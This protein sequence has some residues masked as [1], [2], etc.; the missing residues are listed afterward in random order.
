[1]KCNP[2]SAN[3]LWRRI[4]ASTLVLALCLPGGSPPHA[5]EVVQADPQPRLRVGPVD[6]YWLQKRWAPADGLTAERAAEFEVEARLARA[7]Q[8][9]IIRW[10]N[11]L[12]LRLENGLFVW[13]VDMGD[14]SVAGF[15]CCEVYRLADVWPDLGFYVVF[16]SRDESAGYLL[17]SAR[18]AAAVETVWA[19]HRDPATPGLLVS[20]L[21][22]DM[23]GNAA[24]VWHLENGAWRRAYHCP[25]LTYGTEFRRWDAPGRAVLTVPDG[26]GGER[27]VPLAREGGQ[28]RTD[29]CE[30]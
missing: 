6:P 10:S 5:T 27:E 21:S 19:P 23:L 12:A 15:G 3:P 30:G 2:F 17:I 9:R 26:K 7:H 8:G 11:L 22:D 4:A 1:M 16:L 25:R 13:L 18:T 14:A 29:T 20:V 28:W 24:E